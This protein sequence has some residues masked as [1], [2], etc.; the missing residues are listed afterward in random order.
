MPPIFKIVEEEFGFRP[1]SLY[2]CGG[3]VG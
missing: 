1:N 2:F 3:A